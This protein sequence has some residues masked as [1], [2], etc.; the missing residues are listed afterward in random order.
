MAIFKR[1]RFALALLGSEIVVVTLFMN[2]FLSFA[3]PEKL[4]LLSFAFCEHNNASRPF[5][6]A[7]FQFKLFEHIWHMWLE[8]IC[9][10]KLLP[11]FSNSIAAR[12]FV[13]IIYV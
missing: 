7:F 8:D 1:E 3:F 9:Q 4:L 11:D 12:H 13:F 10:N 2:L 5:F 6:G